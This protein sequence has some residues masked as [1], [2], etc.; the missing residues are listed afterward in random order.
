VVGGAA[1]TDGD[2]TAVVAG[3]GVLAASVIIRQS[4]AR[5][6]GTIMGKCSRPHNNMVSCDANVS[7]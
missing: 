2:D 4:R 7:I 3:R 1:D 5:V 6:G